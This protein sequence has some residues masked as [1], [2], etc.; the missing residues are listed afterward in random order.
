MWLDNKK[1]KRIKVPVLHVVDSQTHI[2]NAVFL[3]GESFRGVWDGFIE[4]WTSV[5]IGYP[6]ALK[7]GTHSERIE[8]ERDGHDAFELFDNFRCKKTTAG[9]NQPQQNMRTTSS[10]V[11]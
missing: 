1:K 8:F 9:V 7:T 5:Y 6:Q 10:T 4:A 2:P 11:N 3:K